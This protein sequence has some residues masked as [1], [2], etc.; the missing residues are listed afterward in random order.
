MV[1]SFFFLLIDLRAAD[2][3]FL[4]LYIDAMILFPLFVYVYVI[5]YQTACAVETFLCSS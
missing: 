4:E 3:K 1:I 5:L 2:T